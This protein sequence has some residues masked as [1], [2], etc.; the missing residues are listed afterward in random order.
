MNVSVGFVANLGWAPQG[1]SPGPS[2]ITNF[3]V[4][5][6]NVSTAAVLDSSSVGPVPS[7]ELIA[8]LV[9]DAINVLL[10]YINNK[11][12][13][14]FA[15][16]IPGLFFLTDSAFVQSTSYLQA[17]TDLIVGPFNRTRT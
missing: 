10:P 4:A 9:A 6:H 13:G 15:I 5:L 8:E 12:R 11:T 16:G 17:S 7:V 2:V 3:S 1:G 14:G